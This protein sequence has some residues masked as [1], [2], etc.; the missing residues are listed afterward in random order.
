MIIKKAI[1]L[2]I[3][4]ALITTALAGDFDREIKARQS[5]MQVLAYNNGLLAGMA[6]GKVPYDAE[7]AQTAAM[8]LKLASQMNMGSVWVPGSEMG[9][10]GNDTKTKAE[11]WS[12]W[13]KAGTYLA[14]LGKASVALDAVAGMGLDQMKAAFSDVGDACSACH[15]DFRAK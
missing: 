3:S 12:T 11:L 7:L 9:V 10:E 5:F 8:N 13:P 15:K 1:F 4:A 14:D 2:C 6:R